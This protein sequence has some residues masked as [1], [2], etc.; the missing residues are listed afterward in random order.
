MNITPT[1][2]FIALALAVICAIVSVVVVIRK[3]SM[4]H[5]PVDYPLDQFTQLDLQE[6]AD[7]FVG[8]EVTSRVISDD[9]K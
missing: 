5:N 4:K 7:Q 3:Y 2:F 1:V 6:Q 9:K 8:K